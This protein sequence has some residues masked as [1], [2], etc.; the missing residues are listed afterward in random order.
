MQTIKLAIFD[1]D[2]VL[3][4]GSVFWT[5]DGPQK[6]YNARD[7][8]GL[9]MLREKK[10]MTA[11]LSGYK[12]NASQR[13][14]ATHLKFDIVE[15]GCKDKLSTVRQWCAQYSFDISTE[16]A[17]IGDDI[18][19][20]ELMR[21]VSWTACP[22]DA[23]GQIRT[24]AQLIC[25]TPGGRGCVREFCEALLEDRSTYLIDNSHSVNLNIANA[26]PANLFVVLLAADDTSRSA[27]KCTN[28]L[29]ILQ[30]QLRTLLMCGIREKQIVVVLRDSVQFGAGLPRCRV[31]NVSHGLRS[32]TIM[33]LAIS[34]L[35][36]EG[37]SFDNTKLMVIH[38]NINLTSEF[39]SH[40]SQMKNGVLTHTSLNT[41]NKGI[42]VVGR[43]R[44]VH[45]VTEDCGAAF[46]RN[47]FS[48]MMTFQN[49]VL[50]NVLQFKPDGN[51]EMSDVVLLQKTCAHHNIPLEF[52][53]INEPL[54]TSY[55]LVGG[56]LGGITCH[57]VVRKRSVNQVRKLREEIQWL[58]TL[59]T[60]LKPYFTSVL[61]VNE[62]PD[63]LAYYMP[64]YP[65]SSFRKH[66]LMNQSPLPPLRA[67]LSN[68]FKFVFEDLYVNVG[69]APPGFIQEKHI[70]RVRQRFQYITTNNEIM[71]KL[72]AKKICLN[73]SDIKWY[74]PEFIEEVTS[75][76]RLQDILK[77]MHL[78]RIHGDLHFQ[79][80][81][82]K[83]LSEG[84]FILV[85]PRGE[86]K[87][88]DI[89]YDLGKC[90]HS[91]HGLYDLIHT[92]YFTLEQQTDGL[93]VN[94]TL[95]CGDETMRS[96]YGE[97]LSH[98]KTLVNQY[99]SDDPHWELKILFNEIM[100]FSSLFTFHVKNDNSEE[101]A[102]ALYCTA[103]R[104]IQEFASRYFD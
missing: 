94:I 3:S 81:L 63:E 29:S 104:L 72:S 87:G 62:T 26:P 13:G 48:G 41:E 67:M 98:C 5:K 101:R 46:P 31:I 39:V 33:S 30:N 17:F 36:E 61:F 11:M 1:F 58:Q 54:Q 64:Y 25:T 8:V 38:G 60:R 71:R 22:S 57:H 16:V 2:N 103:L 15:L 55:E 68:V 89:Y 59:E 100:H 37:E 34:H 91:C 99:M 7:G 90:W 56:S 92:E 43:G 23:V 93:N 49:T 97:V 35:K 75:N 4:D 85:D 80:I 42:F 27:L 10:I 45:H 78:Y 14:I 12:E 82:V 84:Q 86:L 79:N 74:I 44:R 70:A 52:K 102:I 69:E 53:D 73:G 51:D 83:D 18:N 65:Y 19:D 77:P 88:S 66:M 28:N 40:L 6:C 76:K 9:T 32:G 47:I 50:D 20:L 95:E 24:C 96:R 21:T